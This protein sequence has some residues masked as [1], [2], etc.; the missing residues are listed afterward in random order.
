MTRTEKT[1]DSLIDIDGPSDFPDRY[2]LAN[3]LHARP[4]EKLTPPEQASY[5]AMLTGEGNKQTDLNHLKLLCDRFGVDFPAGDVSYF[6]ADFGTFRLRWERHTE[7]TGYTFLRQGN[8][9]EPFE[10]PPINFV[11]KDWLKALPGQRLVAVHL[12]ILGMDSINEDVDGLHRW[13]VSNSLV[14]SAITSQEAQIWTDLRIH[15]D[16]YG[17]ILVCNKGLNAWKAGRIVQRLFE[18]ETY[19]NMALLALPLARS[20]GPETATMDADLARMTRLMTSVGDADAQHS[21]KELLQE[22]TS[23]SAKLENL[24]ASTA[25]RFSA[26]RAYY[27]LTK[28]RVGDLSEQRVP[29]YQRFGRFLDRRLAPAMRTCES[30]NERLE[31]LSRRA[32]R[33]TNLLRT[34]VDFA[35]EA[36]NQKLLAT[37]DK[38]SAVQLRMQETV[39]GLSVAAISY[40]LVGLVN[41]IA[42]AAKAAELPIDTNIV[43]G[44]SIPIVIAIVWYSVRRVKKAILSDVS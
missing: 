39:E 26:S 40:Y 32:N 16:G 8:F 15:S 41:Y 17:R 35:L 34:R 7:F 22:L 20:I 23:L 11:P 24:S 2:V 21:D 44:V 10:E 29:G 14:T 3:E 38:R 42:K 27:S 33:A 6:S 31:D 12:A 13:F 37:M 30:V 19:R 36:Q 5:Y 18:I 43:V 9:A 1:E 25:Y 4:F 28:E